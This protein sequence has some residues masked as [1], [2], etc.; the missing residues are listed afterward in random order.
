MIPVFQTRIGKIS[1]NCFAACI[2]SI[3]EVPLTTVPDFGDDDERTFIRKLAD[4]MSPLDLY[5]TQVSS[6]DPILRE[7]FRFGEAYHTI[8]GVSP[9]G[10]LHACVGRNGVIVHDP[11]P[12]ADPSGLVKV[13]CFGLI[14]NRSAIGAAP[15]PVGPANTAR[16]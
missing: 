12:G 2:A 15:L 16:F 7:M 5:Y 1:G 6:D 8:E 11:H 4:W 13:E 3:L 14:C 10:G 9:R